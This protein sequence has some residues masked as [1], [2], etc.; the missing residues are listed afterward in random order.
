M[1]AGDKKLRFCMIST[2]Y[3]PYNFGGDGLY[4]WLLS[5]E[6]ARRGHSVTVIHCLDSYAA[7]AGDS[8][9]ARYE[10]HQNVEVHGLKS[11]V[12]V[13]SPLA[14]QQ[15]GLPLFKSGKLKRILAPGFDV[16][17][18]HNISL[19]GGPGILSYG[20]GVKLYSIHEYWLVCPTHV[21]MRF[22]KAPCTE[23]HCL[24]CQLA[25]GRPPQLWRYTGLLE[26]S[27]RN[28]DA[29][30]S[31]SRF[32]K[33]IH[34][35]MGVKTPIVHIPHFAVPYDGPESENGFPGELPGAGRPYFLYV[36]RVERLKG[37]H[38]LIPVF[39]NYPR[40]DLVIVGKGD[41]EA[42]IKKLAAG[43]GNIHI[44]GHIHHS[45]LRGLYENAAALIVPSIAY[46]ISTLVVFEALREKTPVIVNDI[47]GLP[48]LVEE[49]GGGFIY[50]TPE[51][52]RRSMD[53]ILDDPALRGKLGAL[54]HEAYLRKW[55]PDAHIES[56]FALI[57]SV[58]P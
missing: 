13:F 17:H 42:Y 40:A 6:L 11:A 55:N 36:G 7:L 1:S 37:V 57:N 20:S 15:T 19:I 3:P 50:R 51:E 54:G 12:G 4:V 48:E 41:D 30:I 28:L 16:T 25:H 2:F 49:S 56:Y 22:G 31:P 14:T 21:L 5:N 53:A 43:A 24:A 46:E 58:R 47:G 29:M 35:D 33:K 34:E 39:K 18:F 9:H 27:L 38:T 32:T 23:P 44:L 52:L 45:R 10:N 8:P 26:R